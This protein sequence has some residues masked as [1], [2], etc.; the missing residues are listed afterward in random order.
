MLLC[1]LYMQNKEMCCYAALLIELGLFDEININ[2]LIVGHT[3]CNLDQN[4]SVLSNKI[5]TVF[6]GRWTA[7]QLA[8]KCTEMPFTECI[9][10][11]CNCCSLHGPEHTK[12]GAWA[13]S[14]SIANHKIAMQLLRGGMN[15]MDGGSSRSSVASG[16]MSSDTPI[17]G[18]ALRRRQAVASGGPS[19]AAV[20]V[21]NT[22]LP[23]AVAHAAVVA[24]SA[25]DIVNLSSMRVNEMK[26]LLRDIY[27]IPE[28]QLAGKNGDYLKL[29]VQLQREKSRHETGG[30]EFKEA[31]FTA[32]VIE[33][34]S[35]SGG[36]SSSHR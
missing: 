26:D 29:L 36:G 27:G 11:G 35:R 10:C 31:A 32:A 20:V 16:G 30:T 5:S 2:F 28:K 1:F 18:G 22:G 8:S 9:T 6:A 13:T 14:E 24:P 15:A 23:P 25:A 17:V 4:F 34:R 33:Q 12:H 21:A 19:S 3:H 7:K